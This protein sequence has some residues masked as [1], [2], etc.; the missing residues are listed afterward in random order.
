MADMEA[1]MK[2]REREPAN[3]E[4]AL[5]A[6]LRAEVHLRAYNNDRVGEG[7]NRRDRRDDRRVEGRYNCAMRHARAG[8]LN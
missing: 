2:V 7:R 5:K 8:Q 6:A 3:L 1:E 4:R